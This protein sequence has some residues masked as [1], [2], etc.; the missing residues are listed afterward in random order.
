MKIYVEMP[1]GFIRDSF[2]TEENIA[3]LESLGEVSWNEL[4][5]HLTPEEF[6]DA[7]EGVDVCVCGWGVPRFDGTVLEKADKLKLVAYTAGSVAG[8][9][10]EE[11]YSR[12]IRIVAGNDVFARTV[13]EAALAHMLL[14]L[15]R[16]PEYECRTIPGGWKPV[17]FRNESLF[18][19]T[20]GIVGLG[21][22]SRH[23]LKMLQP[24]HPRI[25]LYSGHT[26]P[27]EAAAL[28]VEKAT[29]EDIF[30]QCRIISLHTA[31]STANHHLVGEAL[32]RLMGQDA[33][34][35]N[36]ARGALIDEEALLRHLRSGH[37]RASLDVY[38]HEPL[39]LDHPLRSLHN[40]HLQPH[41]AGPTMDQRPAA[42][43][44]VLEDIR[45][46][47]NGESLFQE[48]TQNRASTMTR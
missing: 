13:A 29:L 18:D 12:G 35:I 39:P 1:K 8:I 37:I 46:F 48:I 22:T 47:Q 43:R 21:A 16:F 31:K 38:Q 42:A 2:L 26:T 32:L 5:R 28:G 11:M 30:S 36:T 6:R 20:I 25:L 19:N 45:R 33:I 14:M 34:L 24:F 10:S 41:L 7:L 4:E 3:Y 17:D 27:E 40:V 9:V 23:L 15:R 44:I